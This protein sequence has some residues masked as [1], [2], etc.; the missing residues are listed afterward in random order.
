MKY[1]ISGILLLASVSS[2]AVMVDDLSVV[3]YGIYGNGRIFISFDKEVPEPGC[4]RQRIDIDADHEQA[5]VITSIA[6]AALASGKKVKV[7]TSGC[8][9][10]SPTLT[11]DTSSYIYIKQ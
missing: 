11:S 4:N 8:F 9:A 10:N 3:N 7:Q 6:L 2:A 5:D 1:I